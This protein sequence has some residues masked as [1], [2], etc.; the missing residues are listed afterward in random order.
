M[1]GW[2]HGRRIIEFDAIVRGLKSCTKCR[3][4]PLYLTERSIKGEMKLGLGGYIY[5]QCGNCLFLNRIAY[6]ITHKLRQSKG[7]PNFSVNTKIG[8]GKHCLQCELI[9]RE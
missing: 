2:K 8:T 4:G 7:M 6:G 3:L 9:I 5:V 1:D